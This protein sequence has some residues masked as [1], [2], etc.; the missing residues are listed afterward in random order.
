M[1]FRYL[2][3]LAAAAI[4]L[5]A[6]HEDPNGKDP[7]NNGT[8]P[9]VNPEIYAGGLLGT[10]FN[11]SASA[12][13]DP[14][15]AVEKAGL[16]DRFKYGE[17]FFERS[18]TQTAEPFDGL[19]PLYI[20]NSCQACHPGYGHGKRMERYRWDDWG[21]GYLLVVYDKSNDAYLSGNIRAHLPGSDHTR[22]R[23]LRA[24]PVR[25]QG[26]PSFPGGRAA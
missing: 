25:R 26:Y 8:D 3:L 5:T 21:N 24:Y 19:G 20:R 9:D 6:C 22:E 14:A 11:S 7:D 15:P 2:S 17:Y 12:F 4:A 18:Y 13:E 1:K 10:T 16:T 23:F